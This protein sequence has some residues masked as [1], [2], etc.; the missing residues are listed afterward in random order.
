MVDR[1]GARCP[2]GEPGEVFS[3]ASPGRPM[4]WLLEQRAVDARRFRDAWFRNG[5]LGLMRSNTS[6]LHIVEPLSDTIIIEAS[7]VYPQRPWRPCS[8]T[9]RSSR[10]RRR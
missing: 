2:R 5:D 1:W 3:D 4:P 10:E 7:N 6:Y 9:A 8:R